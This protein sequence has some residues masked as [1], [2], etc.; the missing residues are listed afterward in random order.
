M[1]RQEVSKWDAEEMSP[2]RD[3]PPTNCRFKYLVCSAP[4][5]GSWLLCTGLAST[6]LAGRP[7]EFLSYPY[8]EAY[9]R[10]TGRL[11]LPEYWQFLLQRRTSPNG[12]F[13]MKIH[14]DQF[15]RNLKDAEAQQEFLEQFDRLI[16]MTR[17]DKLAQAVS[18]L[19]AR[20]TRVYHVALG[21]SGENTGVAP[22][23]SFSQIAEK[24]SNIAAQE[25]LWLSLLSQC[26]EKTIAVEYEDL[27]SDYVGTLQKVLIA[28]DLG[29]AVAAVNP[30]PQVLRQHDRINSAWEEQFMTDLRGRD[31]TRS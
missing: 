17:R 7:A 1:E 31:W 9:R 10:R 30:I 6:G 22:D 19:K 14:F 11:R 4:R 27:V 8:A 24:L 28:L 16:F 2:A 15:A 3:F 12:V 21:E 23:Y 13:G 26:R 29:D 5:S 18:F 20:Q 25:A